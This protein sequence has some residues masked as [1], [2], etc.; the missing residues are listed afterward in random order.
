MKFRPLNYSG[1][2]PSRVSNSLKTRSNLG[3]INVSSGNLEE[4]ECECYEIKIC[5][6]A[7]DNGGNGDVGCTFTQGFW[8]NHPNDWPVQN[9]T[10]GTVNYTKAE[11]LSI[12]NQPVMG[13]GLISLAHQLIA[14]KLNIA[15]GAD[16]SAI[17]ATVLAADALIGGLVIPPIGAGWLAPATTSALTTL[18]DSYNNGLLGVPHCE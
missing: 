1:K 7:C 15:N 3:N 8:K 16:D 2:P 6:K 17:A 13:N 12:L 5:K 11:L 4:G 14:T 18:L 9:L 10:L